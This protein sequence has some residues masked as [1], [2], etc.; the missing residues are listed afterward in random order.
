MVIKQVN[1]LLYLL[2]RLHKNSLLLMIKNN[3]DNLLIQLETELDLHMVLLRHQL[4]TRRQKD[5]PTIALLQH[6]TSY[7]MK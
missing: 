3:V 6:L 7:L 4:M 2:N 5:E 1:L